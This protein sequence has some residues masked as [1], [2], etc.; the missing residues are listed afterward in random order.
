MLSE[1]V[2]LALIGGICG[3]ASRHLGTGFAPCDRRANRPADRRSQS[4]SARPFRDLGRRRSSPEL[5]LASVPA[6]ASG[7]PELTEALKEGGRGST[8]GL[9]RNRLRNALVVAEVALALVL[10]VGASLLLKSFVRLQNVDPGFDPKNV[11]T[12]ELALPLLKY[13]RGKPVAD[14]YAEV[15]RRV[16]ALPG[17]GS[18]CLHLHS[19]AQRDEQ[20]QLFRDRRSRSD[21]G[22]GLSRRRDS[23]RDAG[24]FFSP[25]GAAPA[26]PLL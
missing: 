19:A 13:P 23:R 1:S 11:L 15:T 12:M 2:L 10:L 22:E 3:R 18:R 25:Q 17:R 5:S 21:A 26:G 9:R 16:Q 14:F 20:R 7:K 4:R 8:S 6:L 24:L